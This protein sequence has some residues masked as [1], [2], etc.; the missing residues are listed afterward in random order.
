[1]PLEELKKMN[2][3]PSSKTALDVPLTYK[4]PKN[5]KKKARFAPEDVRARPRMRHHEQKE[6][7]ELGKYLTHDSQ[8]LNIS[9]T[10]IKTFKSMLPE[11]NF[12]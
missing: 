3:L 9:G 1:M 11:P 10:G 8:D 5:A 7:A 2:C 6:A 12:S 4:T